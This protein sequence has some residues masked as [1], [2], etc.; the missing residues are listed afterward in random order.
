MR[1]SPSQL[2]ITKVDELVKSICLAW[3]ADKLDPNHAATSYQQQVLNTVA[4]GVP[5]IQA[6]Q[7]W[8]N[9]VAGLKTPVSSR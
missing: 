4:S 8:I 6:I 1:C 3:A 5:E 7:Q 2:P 9:Y